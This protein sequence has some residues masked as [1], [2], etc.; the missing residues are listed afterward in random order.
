MMHEGEEPTVWAGRGWPAYL[1]VV[2]VG[3]VG[4]LMAHHSMIF[5]GLRCVQVDV[6]DSRLVNYLLEHAYLWYVG[7][8]QHVDFWNPQIFYPA[9]NIAAYCDTMISIAPIYCA[10]R[11]SGLAP[12]TSFQLWTMTIS[13]LN[14]VAMLH[15][16][17]WRLRLSVPAATVGAFVFAFGA[18]RI[19]MLV[20]QTLLPQFLSLIT[21]DALFGLFP[22]REMFWWKRALLWLVATAGLLAQLSSGFYIGWFTVF[23]LGIATIVAVWMPSTRGPFL[24]TLRRDLPWLAVSAVIGALVMRPWFLHHLAARIEL[25]PRFLGWISLLQPHPTTW[26]Q[27][28]DQNWVAGW[29]RRLT[30]FRGFRVFEHSTSIGVGLV[31]TLACLAGLYLRRDR[32]SVRLLI[33]VTAILFVCITLFPPGLVLAL[34]FLLILGSVAFAYSGRREQPEV[35]FL[36]LGL[37]LLFLVVDQFPRM[38]LLGSGLYTLVIAVAAFGGRRDDQRGRVI[39]GALIAG[40]TLA[41]IPSLYVLAVGAVFG[42]ALAYGPRRMGWRS[43]SQIEAVAIAG[44]L[45][46]AC[47]TTYWGRWGVLSIPLLAPLAIASVR[48]SPVRPPAW[49]LPKAAF[50]GLLLVLMFVNNISAWSYIFL[51]VPGAS[52]LLFVG[53]VGLMMLIPWAIGIGFFIDELLARKRTLLALVIG[54]ICLLEQG[55]TTSAFD[56]YENREVVTALAQRVDP[57]CEA[58]YYSPHH[59]RYTPFKANL[60]AMWA[61]LECRKPTLNGYSG[62]TPPAWRGLEDSN[63]N[64]ERDSIRL[65][66]E[67]NRWRKGPGRAVGRVQWVGGPL[68]WVPGGP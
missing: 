30:G 55:V 8:P 16:L 25:G 48:R 65:Q 44:L 51:H 12:D 2:G 46:F 35:F 58:F 67:L 29:M 47:V 7:D 36:V 32:P 13:V 38:L 52:S 4:M 18:S 39:L 62:H 28:G 68:E 6:G 66:W 3:V 33:A 26:L 21:I 41:L 5:S 1:L 45:F 57:S 40:L 50:F 10:Y 22:V 23:S 34:E 15:L 59:A 14:Y 24:A 20:Q 53:R 42:G 64:G 17:R 19:N 27:V 63:Y 56:K 37:V 11:A 54:S 61:G 49:S 9:R 43:R 60:D 31:T